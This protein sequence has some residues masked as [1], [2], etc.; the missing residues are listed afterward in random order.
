VDLIVENIEKSD[1]WGIDTLNWLT[2]GSVQF[3]E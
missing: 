3:V 1:D 2:H